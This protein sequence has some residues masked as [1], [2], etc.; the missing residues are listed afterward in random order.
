MTEN[1]L[2]FVEFIVKN[3][4][5]SNEFY[6]LGTLDEM[7]EYANKLVKDITEEEFIDFMLK[8]V[9]MY[10]NTELK[11]LSEEEMKN[12]SGYG[13]GAKAKFLSYFM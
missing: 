2:K 6:S 13:I 4:E 12:V 8:C 7:Y 5:F 10:K 1:Q 9:C 3:S 11:N